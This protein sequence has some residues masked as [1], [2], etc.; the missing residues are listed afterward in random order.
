MPT[1]AELRDRYNPTRIQ[2]DGLR[3]DLLRLLSRRASELRKQEREAEARELAEGERKLYG[4]CKGCCWYRFGSDTEPAWCGY[5][6]EMAAHVEGCVDRNTGEP[7][8]EAGA[9]GDCIWYV[10]A[11]PEEPAPWCKRRGDIAEQKIGGTCD[12]KILKQTCGECRFMPPR[13]N[14]SCRNEN[15][16]RSVHTGCDADLC[17]H[18]DRLTAANAGCAR[19]LKFPG[20]G[21][22]CDT[23]ASAPPRRIKARS[24][25]CRNFE[26][27]TPRG[28]LSAQFANW[29]QIVKQRFGQERSQEDWIKEYCCETS[30]EE[31]GGQ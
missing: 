28:L 9:C 15:V 13:Q 23:D 6:D 8:E 26:M 16:T 27:H 20:D 19:C 7:A 31:G 24:K 25:T 3:R 30:N 17:Q 14:F 4:D 12:A 11:T 18:F 5:R 2:R 21:Y 29:D 10:P 22:P 1:I